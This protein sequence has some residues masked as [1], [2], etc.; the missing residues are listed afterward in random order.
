MTF[1][2]AVVEALKDED[3]RFF[4]TKVFNTLSDSSYCVYRYYYGFKDSYRDSTKILRN[5]SLDFLMKIFNWTGRKSRFKPWLE[6]RFKDLLTH[7]L[8]YEPVWTSDN[9]VKIGCK[10]YK[11]ITS[12]N[13]KSTNDK[14]EVETEEQ[15][16]VD[17]KNC[18]NEKL[19]ALYFEYDAKGLIPKPTKNIIEGLRGIEEV[20]EN[21]T[22]RRFIEEQIEKIHTH[23]LKAATKDPGLIEGENPMFS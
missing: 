20:R 21:N 10:N 14:K 15:G 1:D 5:R 13:K 18:S 22:T 19:L 17:I 6:E 11:N 12:F 9:S 16:L 23:E 7:D 3:K 2:A 8:I 4:L